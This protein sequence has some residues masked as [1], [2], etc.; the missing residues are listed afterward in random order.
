MKFVLGKS[1]GRKVNAEGFT[2]V[3]IIVVI[4]ITGIVAT[5]FSGLMVSS[6]KLYTDRNLRFS[7]LIDH[8][9]AIE[10]FQT[11]LRAKYRWRTSPSATLLDFDR[12]DYDP[13]LRPPW[14]QI[15]YQLVRTGYLISGNRLFFKRDEGGTTWSNNYPLVDGLNNTSFS[16]GIAGGTERVTIQLAVVVGGKPLRMRTTVFPRNQGTMVPLP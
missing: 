5:L 10:S 8:R 6:M 7:A 11:D 14:F 13:N 3:E 15:Y 2:L 16:S 9:R 4:I 12:V 1:N